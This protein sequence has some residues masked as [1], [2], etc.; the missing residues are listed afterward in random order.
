MINFIKNLFKQKELE[1]FYFEELVYYDL[2][3]MPDLSSKSNIKGFDATHKYKYC[4]EIKKLMFR[5]WG[6]STWTEKTIEYKSEE[7]INFIK[8]C[9]IEYNRDKK[10]SK[11]L[12]NK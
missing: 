12:K 11:I 10:L 8:N 9:D 6:K 1:W 7:L 2:S 3:K 4:P 5:F